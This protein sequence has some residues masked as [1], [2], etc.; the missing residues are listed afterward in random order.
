M[1]ELST[2]TS[3][4]A[5]SPKSTVVSFDVV[6]RLPVIVTR[7]PPAIGPSTGSM[8]MISGGSILGR[9]KDGFS[10]EGSAF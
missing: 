8:E 6:N 7:V 1:L 4:A 5:S 9:P 10:G 2:C 3:A